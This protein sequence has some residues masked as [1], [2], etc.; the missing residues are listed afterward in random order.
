M[1]STIEL[2]RV[3][4]WWP[5]KHNHGR[6]APAS[7]TGQARRVSGKDAG[8]LAPLLPRSW[9]PIQSA[10]N[11]QT[12]SAM[13]NLGSFLSLSYDVPL[14]RIT[15]TWRMPPYKDLNLERQGVWLC[16]CHNSR[17][18]PVIRIFFFQWTSGHRFSYTTG[19]GSNT[20]SRC[21]GCRGIYVCRKTTEYP[22]TIYALSP[23]RPFGVPGLALNY[24]H[25]HT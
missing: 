1:L 21:H 8:F 7:T 19:R 13:R 11:N 24:P 9:S 10:L 25:H 4:K 6:P 18:V 3:T 20:T 22:L 14:N 12:K 16:C 2:G 15:M 5:S 23:H 17:N